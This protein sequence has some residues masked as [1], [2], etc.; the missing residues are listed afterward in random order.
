MSCYI[1]SVEDGGLRD[2]NFYEHICFYDSFS[3]KIPAL[4]S[5][6]VSISEENIMHFYLKNDTRKEKNFYLN[7]DYIIFILVISIKFFL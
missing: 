3:L 4:K 5:N 1:C 2:I 6:K 7:A